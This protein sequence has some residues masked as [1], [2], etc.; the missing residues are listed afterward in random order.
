MEKTEMNKCRG[1]FSTFSDTFI[2]WQFESRC[3]NLKNGNKIF[4]E[5][6][7]KKDEYI[8]I[9]ST[10]SFNFQHY[11][12]HDESHSVCILQR[13][14]QIL[15]RERIELLSAGDLWLILQVAYSHDIGMA[16]THD[17]LVDLW[18]NDKDFKEYLDECL[19]ED[20]EDLHRAAL[21]MKEADNLINKK[22]Q[23]HD[24]EG[25]E[26]L[27]FEEDWQIT[28]ESYLNI[29]VAEYIRKYHAFRAKDK[30]DELDPR[31]NPAIAARLYNI[32][33][34]VVAMHACNFEDIFSL[35]DEEDGF[36]DGNMHP[37]FVAVMLRLGDLL[38]IDNN[39]FDPYVVEHFG[40]LPSASLLH[41]KKHKAI[42]HISVSEDEISVEA[43][44]D[45][46]DVAVVSDS[47][48]KYIDREVENLICYW[49]KLV[50]KELIGCRMKKSV[51]KTF[52][53]GQLFDSSKK[54]EF[55]VNK[56]RLINLLIGTSVYQTDMECIR[57][58]IQN[59]LDASKV[60]LWI[61]LIN[62]KYDS[63]RFKN[64]EV[65][66]ISQLTPLDLD[67]RVYENYQI[68]I[69]VE[70][71]EK[72]DKIRMK[73][74]D[75]GIGI[76]REYMEKLSTIGTGWHGR[77][78]YA[79]HMHKMA[80]WLRPTGGF[81]IGMQSAFM[82]TDSVEIR[83]K[84]DK[85]VC[86]YKVVL[87]KEKKTGTVAITELKHFMFRGTT[88]TYEISPE[89]F[90]SW[91][92]WLTKRRKDEVSYLGEKKE[93][94]Y[95]SELLDEFDEDGILLYVE[96][97][98]KNYIQAIL[99]NS[100]FPIAVKSSITQEEIINKT[101]WP[102]EPYWKEPSK[103]IQVEYN[104][105]EFIGVDVSKQGSLK[106]LI[107]NKT[108]G[109]F[110][111]IKKKDGV[112]ES[113]ICYKN[114]IVR[115]W[116]KTKLDIFSQYTFIV[117]FMG[118]PV[119]NCLHL[120]RNSFLERFDLV[121]P[122][123]ECFW[124]YLFFLKKNYTEYCKRE[125]NGKPVDINAISDKKGSTIE[126]SWCLE[127]C[128][129]LLQLMCIIEYPVLMT[130]SVEVVNQNIGVERFER[131]ENGE[132]TIVKKYEDVN[133][134]LGDIRA[135]YYGID[136]DLDEMVIQDNLA[137]VIDE[138]ANLTSKNMGKISIKWNWACDYFN[139]K[140]ENNHWA[141]K[142]K[143][144]NTIFRVG[145]LQDEDLLRILKN[146]KGLKVSHFTISD[147]ELRG[148]MLEHRDPIGRVSESELVEKMWDLST[149]KRIMPEV[150][151]VSKYKEIQ[152][153]KLPFWTNIDDDEEYDD[154]KAIYII[155][156]LSG[157][158]LHSVENVINTGVYL[159]YEK[160][161]QYV[162]GERGQ[163]FSSYH[164]LIEFVQKNQIEAKY[165]S[166]RDIK[167]CYEELL[168]DIYKERVLPRYKEQKGK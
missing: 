120:H 143:L 119:K 71:N 83:T 66:D 151:D 30:G 107:W 121:I 124:V 128:S 1:V 75:N 90:Q 130:S 118:L 152:V 72:K 78:Q 24:L 28:C 134:I 70:W 89:K 53:S 84:S 36:G 100:L 94:G 168:K 125:N 87:N 42:T 104:D 126:E 74:H 99:P 41:M 43:E 116:K 148:Y 88:I 127:W 54:L 34:D 73:F 166:S 35:Q 19:D 101:E 139:E 15:G 10:I 31:K 150:K 133:K 82:V 141:K 137:I 39:R 115:E 97:Y 57:E 20:L 114:I 77:T 58:Y 149:M 27:D 103:Y 110:A 122:V 46:Y 160:F 113:K 140:I 91:T 80:K 9:M 52:L 40:R 111:S 32:S 162:W 14:E 96:K 11:S 37:Q 67:K 129:Y 63:V 51:C 86:G 79:N 138:S 144:L 23:M 155:S 147:I 76:E 65:F 98:L 145:V 62:G 33:N 161:R 158:V 167:D 159:D 131:G 136:M 25:K 132:I 112:S 117:D 81:G 165:Y 50:P 12:R 61:D 164:R 142:T 69:S 44:T 6:C 105:K 49:N 154:R 7:H 102:E 156:P 93:Y 18:K 21:F 17:Q 68:T 13:I 5:W 22:K 47:W 56:E 60:Q 108:D 163:E 106:Y 26:E 16:L 4:T 38:D 64:D 153:D 157:R 29:L 3:N 8:S 109:I 135:F 92:S 2:E 95:D 59:A 45:E 146:D 55:S 48:F 123:K 85:D